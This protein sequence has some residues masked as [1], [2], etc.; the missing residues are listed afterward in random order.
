MKTANYPSNASVISVLKPSAFSVTFLDENGHILHGTV[1][2]LTDD[3]YEVFVKEK[4]VI[5]HCTKSISG[6]LS[7]KLNSKKNAPWVD[8]ISNEI[9]KKINKAN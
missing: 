2:Q 9:A 6:K 3:D 1:K 7:C 4:G 8:G 5:I